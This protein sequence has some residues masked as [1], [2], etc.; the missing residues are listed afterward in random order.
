ML[1]HPDLAKRLTIP[2]LSYREPEQWNGYIPPRMT[3]VSG[4]MTHN[5]SP[6]RVHL[7]ALVRMAMEREYDATVA[8]N[9]LKAINTDRW[10]G[11]WTPHAAIEGN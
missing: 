3:P 4:G 5:D 6:R 11:S 10:S 1:K 7:V 2:P 8:A 9:W